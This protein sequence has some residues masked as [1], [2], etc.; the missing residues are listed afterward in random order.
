MKEVVFL[1]NRQSEIL[2][3]IK[4]GY[5][6]QIISKKTGISINTVKYHLKKIYKKLNVNNRIG[7]INKISAATLNIN[8]YEKK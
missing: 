3:L 8:Y 6:N 4:S 1:T 5:S 2:L 7:A